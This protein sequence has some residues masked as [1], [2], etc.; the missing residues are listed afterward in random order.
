MSRACTFTGRSR[1]TH[2]CHTAPG[3][4]L[5]GPWPARRSPPAALGE[6][7]RSRVLAVMNSPGYQDLAIPQVWARELD[8]GRY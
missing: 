5:H 8:A 7:E 3:G 1:A 2:Y 4:R 6:T